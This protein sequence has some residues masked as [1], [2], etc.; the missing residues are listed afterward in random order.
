MPANNS[1]M[2]INKPVYV[3]GLERGVLPIG[4]WVILI[5]LVNKSVF[6]IVACTSSGSWVSFLNNLFL[7]RG[8][9]VSLIRLDFP[10]PETP[11]MHVS[12]PNGI[13]T[14]TFYKLFLSTFS[15]LIIFE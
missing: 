12:K 1:L 5:T 2:W 6:S 14:E 3:A 13:S 7:I 9:K 8:Y 4:L 10:E 11:V 15:N